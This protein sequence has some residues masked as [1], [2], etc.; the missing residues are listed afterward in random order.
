MIEE[1]F[2]DGKCAAR[3]LVMGKYQVAQTLPL[4]HVGSHAPAL[5][6]LLLISKN[7]LEQAHFVS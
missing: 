5:F 1:D 7:I 4:V 2:E 3:K 6:T